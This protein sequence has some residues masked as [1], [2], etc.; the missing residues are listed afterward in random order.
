MDFKKMQ[1]R[2]EG[3]DYFGTLATRLSIRKME[4]KPP[5]D[6]V[7]E[8]LTFLQEYHKITK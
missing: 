1:T 8:E 7:I 2:I 6:E 5:T 4:N 3:G